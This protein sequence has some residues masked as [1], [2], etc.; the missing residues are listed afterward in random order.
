VRVVRGSGNVIKKRII[1]SF[2]STRERKG[3]N[4]WGRGVRASGKLKSGQVHVHI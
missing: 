4:R 3:T 2:G 1:D